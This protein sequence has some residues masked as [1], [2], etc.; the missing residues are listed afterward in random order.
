MLEKKRQGFVTM[1]SDK[2]ERIVEHLVPS[3]HSRPEHAKAVTQALQDIQQLA[4]DQPNTADALRASESTD[5]ARNV[6]HSH[7]IKITSEALWRHRGVLLSGGQPTW[8]G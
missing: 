7:G 4:I 5:E 3:V 2:S 6:L 1:K 8:R